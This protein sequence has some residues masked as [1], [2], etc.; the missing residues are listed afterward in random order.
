V[1]RKVVLRSG[2]RCSNPC[3][4][5]ELGLQAHHIVWRSQGGL[6]SL[7]NETAVCATCHACLH[8]GT[9]EVEGDPATGLT[10]RRAAERI[11]LDLS[12]ER[13]ALARVPAVMVTAS[14]D[15][16]QEAAQK[17]ATAPREQRALL[18]ALAKL[19]Y[20][21]PEARERLEWAWELAV[22]QLARE[23]SGEELL[24]VAVSGR[25]PKPK[26]AGAA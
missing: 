17:P 12:G 14:P 3:C 11:Q 23:P 16:P 4:R 2:A 15:P 18:A 25:C 6:P 7:A 20:S 10:W 21:R 1:V 19:G 8:L 22:K 24:R 13:Q 26:D 9:L 5:R